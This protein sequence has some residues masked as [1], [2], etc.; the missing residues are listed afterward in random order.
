[1]AAEFLPSVTD[2][3]GYAVMHTLAEEAPLSQR[4]VARRCGLSGTTV[5]SLAEALED[6]GLLVR[7]RNPRDR[8]SYALTLTDQGRSAMERLRDA[9]AAL[10]GRVAASYPPGDL[11][12]LT[13]LLRRLVGEDLDPATPP[14]LADDVA[15][16]IVR[17]H[18]RVHHDFTRAL[19]P[20][21]I[22]PREVGALRALR[23]G[24]AATQGELAR[25]LEVSP[26]TV[27]AI[28]DHLESLDLVTRE[29]DALD[30]RVH[31]LHLTPG[32]Q[33]VVTE[34]ARR[35]TAVIEDRIGGPDGRDRAE[36]VRLLTVF[37]QAHPPV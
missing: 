11:D 14:A 22:E 19:R 32:A 26:A 13:S 17:A 5:T 33:E 27:V 8:R 3:H 34:A 25:L 29:R 7:I 21:G 4:A 36:L 1:M 18:Q 35:S 12:M 10:S 20:L 37:L 24:G 30:R 2:L 6:E 9:V 23:A 16:L 28:V 15:Q 31:R